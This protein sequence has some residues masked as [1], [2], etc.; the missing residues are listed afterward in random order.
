MPAALDRVDGGE[1]HTPVLDGSGM[2]PLRNVSLPASAIVMPGLARS[3]ATTVAAQ[4]LGFIWLRGVL[5]LV[6]PTIAS[7]WNPSLATS[8][9]VL[10]LRADF[11]AVPGDVAGEDR[12]GGGWVPSRRH[13]WCR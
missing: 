1:V 5:S 8:A 4:L 3:W 7:A 13:R 10:V 6:L 12:L 2:P 9:R 11:H